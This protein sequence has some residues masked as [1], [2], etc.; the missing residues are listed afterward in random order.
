M[1]R[2]SQLKWA[3]GTSVFLASFIFGVFLIAIIFL[4]QY[5]VAGFD[6]VTGIVLALA[7]TMLFILFEYAIGPVIVSATTHLQYLNPGEN[8]WLENTVRDLATKS[9]ISMPRLAIVPNQT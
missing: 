4:F 1:A 3:M 7:G 9:G 6:F 5:Y 2:L 8:P